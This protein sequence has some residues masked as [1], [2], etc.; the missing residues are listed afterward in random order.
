V[1]GAFPATVNLTRRSGALTENG[2]ALQYRPFDAGIAQLVER[3]LAKV[4]VASSS[5]VSRSRY[6]TSVLNRGFLF[7]RPVCR[8]EPEI[9]RLN[10]VNFAVFQCFG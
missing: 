7:T 9:H 4:E 6:K 8:P 3:N 2:S 10:V 5:L 1:A